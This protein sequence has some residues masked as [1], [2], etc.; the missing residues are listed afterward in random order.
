MCTS[1]RAETVAQIQ[2][3]LYA[4]QI[5]TTLPLLTL[6]ASR[7]LS[8]MH[9]DPFQYVEAAVASALIAMIPGIV[10]LIAVILFGAATLA[11]GDA[12]SRLHLG[13]WSALF[14]AAGAVMFCGSDPIVAP[15][16]S[17]M[18]LLCAT[19]LPMVWLKRAVW[20]AI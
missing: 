20:G 16:L 7:V 6:S 4:A 5:F 14:T 8:D 18:L 11:M 13:A 15:G 10:G 3:P 17:L 12:R 19:G 2:P 9:S 1:A